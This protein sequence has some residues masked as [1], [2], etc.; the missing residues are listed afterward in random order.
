MAQDSYAEA[1]AGAPLPGIVPNRGGCVADEKCNPAVVGGYDPKGLPHTLWG[2]GV[3][4]YQETGATVR[5]FVSSMGAVTMENIGE[6]DWDG[7]KFHRWALKEMNGFRENCPAEVG[8]EGVDPEKGAPGWD[9]ESPKG[10]LGFGYW[11]AAPLQPP[12]VACNVGFEANPKIAAS[13]TG[14][15]G[16]YDPLDKM[17]FTVPPGIDPLVY[18][19]AEVN[20]GRTI[21]ANEPLS[22]GFRIMAMP[23]I[24]TAV[25]DATI[26]VF[27]QFRHPQASAEQRKTLKALSDGLAMEDSLPMLQ[28]V[29]ILV[30]VVGIALVGLAIFLCMKG[31]GAKQ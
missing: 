22:V 23:L 6:M 16:V 30:L 1:M 3:E 26:P 24:Y 21:R 25:E 28:T 14:K 27:M 13:D 18:I 9:C 7:V 19:D 5:L 10:C 8:G 12:L 17:E 29:G 4:G 15:I 20:T 11:F 31:G 2:A